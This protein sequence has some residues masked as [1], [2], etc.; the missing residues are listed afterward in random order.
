MSAF[1]SP[2]PWTKRRS[3]RGSS[4]SSREAP[5]IGRASRRMTW[6]E[7]VAGVATKGQIL[8]EVVERTRGEEGTAVTIKVRQ[9]KETKVPHVYDHPRPARPRDD[10]QESANGRPA[11]GTSGSMG[12][13][14]IGYLGSAEISASTPHELRKLAGQLETRGSPGAGARPARLGGRLRALRP[15]SWPIASWTMARSGGSGRPAARRSIRPT[16]TPCSAAGRW[17]CSS[18]SHRGDRRVAG[19]GPSGQ[20]SGHDRRIA[21]PPVVEAG[22]V[23][24]ASVRSASSVGDGS[25]SISLA[26][27]RLERGDGR[28]LERRGGEHTRRRFVHEPPISTSSAGRETDRWNGPYA[29]PEEPNQTPRSASE[30]VRPGTAFPD[31]RQTRLPDRRNPSGAAEPS[32][33]A[34]SRRARSQSP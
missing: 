21:H 19:G 15:C 10:L 34:A 24:G 27:G 22:P 13:D 12:P 26:T 23:R 5:R 18:T 2:W 4:R 7:E 3:G 1:I 31:R 8:R 14:P 20:S 32:A 6:L 16:P 25:W 30:T 28:P 11:A 33:I 9:P 29:S 17:P